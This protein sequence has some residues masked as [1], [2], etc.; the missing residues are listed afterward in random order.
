MNTSLTNSYQSTSK[1][2]KNSWITDPSIEDPDN[3]PEPLGWCLLV[4]PYPIVPNRANSSLILPQTEM[5]FLNHVSNIGRVVAVGDSCWTRPEHRNS[6]GEFNPWAKVGDFI[7]Y[8][9]NVG[10]RRKFKDVSFVILVDD[11]IL[12]KLPD[13]QVFDDGFL[14]LD[15]PQEHMEKYNTIHNKKESK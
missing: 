6:K 14:K 13:P 10:A 12:E 11:E 2:S 9:K 1:V 8:P 7:S 15:I 5:D 4:R 3:L